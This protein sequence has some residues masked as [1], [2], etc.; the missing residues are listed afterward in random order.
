MGIEPYEPMSGIEI[1]EKLKISDDT[2]GRIK[3]FLIE[4]DQIKL[5]NLGKAILPKHDRIIIKQ[6]PTKRSIGNISEDSMI[7]FDS[8]DDRI[9]IKQFKLE[10]NIIINKDQTLTND[11]LVTKFGVGNMG[12]IRYSSVNNIIVLCHTV[13]KYYQDEII[14]KC[15]DH[16]IIQGEAITLLL[17]AACL[18]S[19]NSKRAGT[20]LFYFRYFF[21]FCDNCMLDRYKS[22]TDDAEE[23]VKP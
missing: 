9:E 2:V 15:I 21:D 10:S 13:A 6:K 1:A 23:S 22:R 19:W 11:E 12:G 18:F 5:D 16:G 20:G 17:R 7:V 8:K 14:K 4:F 3:K